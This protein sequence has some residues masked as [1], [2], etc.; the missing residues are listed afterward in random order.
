MKRRTLQVEASAARKTLRAFLA[1]ALG[2]RD[3]VRLLGA[4]A[5]YLQGKRVQDPERVLA[6]GNTVM[7]VLEESGTP[8][9]PEAKPSP[10]KL[11]YEDRALLA[12][13]KAPFVNAQ[14]TPGK[15]GDSLLDLATAHLGRPAGL[16][17]R[18]DRE[19][20]GVTVFG[21][22]SEATSA[23]A[24]SFREGLATKV[25][26]AVVTG[27]LPERGTVD[28]PLSKDPSRPGRYRASR[29]ANGVPALTD[30]VRLAQTEGF[31]LVELHPKTGRTHQ[32]RAHLTSLGCPIAGDERYGGAKKVGGLAAPRCLLHAFSLSLPHPDPAAAPL[33]VRAP[34]P[35]DLAVFFAAANLPLPP[36]K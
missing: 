8:V 15:V 5:V 35:A 1:E 9:S 2:D 6:A 22:S 21:K 12:V 27:P 36:G 7:V 30:F 26:L 16:V 3:A 18:L 34:I 28:L 14:P 19:T 25:Y 10:L 31:S 20:S 32:L 24:A 33:L 29:T 23:L 11:L 13:D 4:G 17:H